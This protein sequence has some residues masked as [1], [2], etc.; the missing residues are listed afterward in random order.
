MDTMHSHYIRKK[1]IQNWFKKKKRAKQIKEN[2]PCAAFS[3]CV[4]T[5]SRAH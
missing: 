1:E 2:K 3:T 5:G 4:S